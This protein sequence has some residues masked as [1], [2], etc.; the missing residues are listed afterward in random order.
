MTLP[1]A[2]AAFSG[3]QISSAT[4]EKNDSGDD[5]WAA[6]EAA[7]QENQ[8]QQ[9]GQTWPLSTSPLPENPPAPPMMTN[10]KEKSE[11]IKIKSVHRIE[12]EKIK[13]RSYQL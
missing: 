2:V 5:P 7:V 8:Q 6:F 1:A 13:T 3:P 10:D 11:S 4:E 9:A 12:I